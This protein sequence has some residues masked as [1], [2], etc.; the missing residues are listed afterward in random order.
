MGHRGAMRA[1]VL[2]NPHC[3]RFCLEASA[4]KYWIAS[5][6]GTGKAENR[7]TR[8]TNFSSQVASYDQ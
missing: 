6:T 2:D 7:S 4:S 1:T 5:I 3:D 8:T